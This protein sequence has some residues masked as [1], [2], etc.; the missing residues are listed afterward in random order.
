[1]SADYTI[2]LKNDADRDKALKAVNRAPLGYRISFAEPKRTIEQNDRMWAMLTD[3]S[4]QV[5]YYGRKLVK[6]DWKDLF[7]AAIADVRVLPKLDGS[8][9]VMVG[10]RT[11]KMGK[12][13]LSDLME[14]IAAYG[15]EHGVVFED[16][17]AA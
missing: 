6:E 13:Q 3:I 16:Q 2:T 7:T 11:S 12:S 14:L 1:M 5:E 9:F 4:D 10:L 15:A 17:E 8:G